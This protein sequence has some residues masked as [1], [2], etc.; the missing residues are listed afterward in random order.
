ME[1][2]TFSKKQIREFFK[3]L[4]IDSKEKRDKFLQLAGE[5]DK[6]SKKSEYIIVTDNTTEKVDMVRNFLIIIKAVWV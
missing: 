1:Y 2:E 6:S 5:C 4:D 3:L